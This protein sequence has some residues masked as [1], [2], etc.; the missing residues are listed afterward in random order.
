MHSNDYGEAIGGSI[1]Q[2][3]FLRSDLGSEPKY[4][5]DS[6]GL[7]ITEHIYYPLSSTHSTI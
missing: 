1:V 7:C 6:W 3:D 5:H 2:E 4:K